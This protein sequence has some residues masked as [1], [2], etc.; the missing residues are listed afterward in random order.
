MVTFFY[1]KWN[2]VEAQKNLLHSLYSTD[3]DFFFLLTIPIMFELDIFDIDESKVEAI[4]EEYSLELQSKHVEDVKQLEEIVIEK[5]ISEEVFL[6]V[7]EQLL[8]P[9]ENVGQGK[10]ITLEEELQQTQR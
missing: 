1:T 3:K 2:F 10:E 7:S 6:E 5:E 4:L 9:L 8:Q